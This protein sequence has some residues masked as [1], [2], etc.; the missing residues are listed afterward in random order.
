M[1]L[2]FLNG[3]WKEVLG[4]L[5]RRRWLTAGL[6]AGLG[7]VLFLLLWTAPL[8][9]EA[10]AM[11]RVKRQ[12]DPMSAQSSE[13]S[14]YDKMSFIETHKTMM[15]KR[16]VLIRLMDQHP[17]I[18]AERALSREKM[19]RRLQHAIDI[20]TVRFTDLMTIRVRYPKKSAVAVIANGLIAAYRDWLDSETDK[21][22]STMMSFIDRQLAQA[23]IRLEKI[24]NEVLQYSRKNGLAGIHDQIRQKQKMIQSLENNLL[25]LDI[26]Q[27]YIQGLIAKVKA[28]PDDVTLYLGV[29][30]KPNITELANV[31]DQLDMTIKSAD[32]FYKAEHPKV[33]ELQ[34]KRNAFREKIYARLMEVFQSQILEVNLRRAREKQEMKA[35]RGALDRLQSDRY[36]VEGYLA[37]L[38]ASKDTYLKLLS[39]LEENKILLARQSL[40]KV[41]V[42]ENAV[43]PEKHILPKRTRTF[44]AGMVMIFLLSMLSVYV[45]DR[46]KKGK[47]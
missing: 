30:D 1:S 37:E 12:I 41:D 43:M 19:I 6:T 44:V 3:E 38:Q 18:L 31:Y 10:T 5:W 36:K 2:K 16:E 7:L 8:T 15:T 35:Q 22:L 29:V 45:I 46:L 32:A 26:R 39:K 23:K 13:N 21:S 20:S 9:Y 17:D 27:A 28:K 14:I 24:E 11:V 40:V 34:A 47:Q 42:I 25:E 4:V 33:L